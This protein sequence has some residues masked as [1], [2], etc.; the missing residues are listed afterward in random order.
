MLGLLGA[1]APGPEAATTTLD[2]AMTGLRSQRGVLRVCIASNPVAFPDCR[3]DAHAIRR[4]VPAAAPH[5]RLEGLP[6]GDYAI[7][8]IH[9]A[10][11]NS[12]LDTMMG[13]PREGFGFSRNPAIGFGPPR[14]NAARFTVGTG[15]QA[16]QVR[17]RYLL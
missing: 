11:G 13:I 15:T 6:P 5:L 7:A 8:V 3:D 9:D 12:R 14:F 16:Q 1:M 17:I 4:T 2:L 10:N